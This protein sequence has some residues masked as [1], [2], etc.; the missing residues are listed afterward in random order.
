MTFYTGYLPLCHLNTEFLSKV[1]DLP[2]VEEAR[3]V[4][5]DLIEELHQLFFWRRLA[6]GRTSAQSRLG[7]QY[8]GNAA[9]NTYAAAGRAWARGVIG[10]FFLHLHRH[11]DLCTV[12]TSVMYAS[13]A[14]QK[15]D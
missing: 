8:P 3:A 1:L 5:V 10:G 9:S 15:L 11:L 14:E 12:R 4:C 13:R 7:R 6:G 2:A